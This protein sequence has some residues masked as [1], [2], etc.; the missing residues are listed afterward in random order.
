[1]A[2]ATG[3]HLFGLR[4]IARR[5]F[6][7]DRFHRDPQIPDDLADRS[8][9]LWVENALADEAKTVIVAGDAPCEGFLIGR[10]GKDAQTYVLDLM[11][12]AGASRGRGV[13][14]ALTLHFFLLAVEAGARRVVVGTQDVNTPSLNLY[15]SC[16]F[17]HERVSY[18]HHLHLDG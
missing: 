18:T 6:W 5:S 4:E 2:L 3:D 8:R 11:A 14:R 1:V 9:E 13:G 12:V 17:R 7:H 15:L 16:G 10:R